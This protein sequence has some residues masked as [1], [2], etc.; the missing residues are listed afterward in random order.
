MAN[1]CDMDEK[2]LK[3]NTKMKVIT[4]RAIKPLKLLEF[5]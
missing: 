2:M 1:E 4:G 3:N 5:P